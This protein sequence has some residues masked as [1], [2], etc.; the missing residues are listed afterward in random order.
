MPTYQPGI[1]VIGMETS[2]QLRR[3]FQAL[4]FETYSI[5][6]LPSE[7]DG[8]DMA[9]SDDGLPLGR[10]MVGDVFQEVANLIANDMQPA[11][12]VFHPTCTMHTLSSQWAL[13]DPDYDRY[14]GV[15]YHQRVKPGTL[16]GAARREAREK[17]EADVER[18]KDLPFLKVIENPR[19]TLPT[20]TTLGKPVDVV[21]PYEFGD[22]AS[23]ATCL[24]VFDEDGE[25]CP[26][27]TLDRDPAA[28]VKP[29]LICGA[30]KGRNNYDAAFGHG[31]VHCGA[32]A[33]R[34]LP[35]WANQTDENQNKLTPGDDRWKDRS[36]TYPGIAG[37]LVAKL[38]ANIFREKT[39]AKITTQGILDL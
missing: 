35:R 15:G 23:K 8:E 11:A 21:Q 16:T 17:E 27:M 37:E 9:Y 39:V 2:G 28:Y 32:E 31:C 24:W 34:L 12:G 20:R 36:R 22:D 19:G 3:R 13:K 14:P 26:D 10:H 25:P 5:D 1:I 33:G 38:A 4:G 18:I 7:D 29:R 6:V 30:C